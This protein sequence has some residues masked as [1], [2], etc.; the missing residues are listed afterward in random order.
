MLCLHLL[1]LLLHQLFETSGKSLEIENLLLLINDL[2]LQ[3]HELVVRILVFR[4]VGGAV[5][6]RIRLVE[7]RVLG[8]LEVIDRRHTQVL[9]ELW[10]LS[11]V[12]N[13]SVRNQV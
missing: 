10:R 8:D 12:V 2:L 11:L 4:L 7:N 5:S 1:A 9:I 6:E 3:M 13:V